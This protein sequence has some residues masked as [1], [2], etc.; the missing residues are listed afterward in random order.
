MSK[1]YLYL[2]LAFFIFLN[3]V[4]YFDVE[5]RKTIKQQ[6][7]LK[8]K[9]Q[10]QALYE[11]NKKEVKLL[12]SNQEKVFV[13]NRKLF[14]A[15]NKKETIIFSELQEQIQKLMKKIGGKVTRLN[16]GIVVEKE[17]YKKYPISLNV[18]VVPEDLDDFFEKIRANNKYLFIDS[19]HIS[20]DMKKNMLRLNITIIGYQLI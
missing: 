11:A 8:Y 3:G 2:L 19:I 4:N 17:F 1:Y 14:F 16:S 9:L 5:I 18:E 6:E 15:K 7:L 13:K 10:K 12:I 20:K